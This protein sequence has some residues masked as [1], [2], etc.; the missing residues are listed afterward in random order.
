PASPIDW[1]GQKEALRPGIISPEAWDPIFANFVSSVGST[2]GQMQATLDGNATALGLQGRR[3][4]DAA[5]LLGLQLLDADAD[6]AIPIL[7]GAT[8][9]SFPGP[10]LDPIFSRQ[11]LE[12]IDRRYALGRL[13]RGWT[14]NWDISASTDSSGNVTVLEDGIVRFF[15]VQSD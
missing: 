1:A 8:D 14:D 2:I 15:T 5:R 4:H 3:T 11:F 13:G 7:A 9:V 12:P 6:E 10:G